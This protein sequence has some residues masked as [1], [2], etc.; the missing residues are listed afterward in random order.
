MTEEENLSIDVEEMNLAIV[1]SEM[2]LHC[3]NK[4]WWIDTSAT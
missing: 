1:I 3:N 2:N 4:E